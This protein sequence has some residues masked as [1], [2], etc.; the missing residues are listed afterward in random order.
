MLRSE[1][2]PAFP[3]SLV[4]LLAAAGMAGCGS[5]PPEPAGEQARPFSGSLEV[6]RG[7]FRQ[8]VLLTGELEAVSGKGVM[9]PRTPSMEVQIRWILEDGSEVR[10]GDEVVELDTTAILGDLEQKRIAEISAINEIE[11]EEAEIR[12]RGAEYRLQLEKAAAD[13]EKA[14]LDAEIPEEIRSRRD[15]Q[16]TQLALE[17]ARVA[18]EKAVETLKAHEVASR[19]ELDNLR[20]KLRKAQREINTAEDALDKMTLHA[21]GDGILVVK[22]NLWEGRKWQVGDRAWV[23]LKLAEIPDL[24]AMRVFARLS[25]VDDGKIAK[26]RPAV[27]ILDAY[28]DMPI[29]GRIT[30]IGAVAQERHWRSMQRHFP[31]R[32]ELDRSDP[33]I[34]RPGMSVRVEVESV[35]IEDALMAPRAALDLE[36]ESPVLLLA[37]GSEREVELGPCNAFECV[38]DEGVEESL[39][40]RAQR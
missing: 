4:F 11:Q 8:A 30:E 3:L 19:A 39:Q 36:G 7:E 32:V 16:E 38:I 28:P 2:S 31:V 34:M 22:E 5:D 37:D 9:V 40:L 27:C 18:H 33:E 1:G 26:G 23:G 29:G 13:L 17:K 15:H 12:V 24:T 20:I 21:P 10:E 25:D 14:K 35:R 6:R